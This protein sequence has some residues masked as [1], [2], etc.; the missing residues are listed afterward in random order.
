MLTF[1]CSP[2]VKM[3]ED[4]NVDDLRVGMTMEEVKDIMGE[5]LIERSGKD[6][7]VEFVYS[8]RPDKGAGLQTVGASVLIES[9]RVVKILPIEGESH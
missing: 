2:E 8:R 4:P 3:G 7:K 5:P 9:G 1:A 6:E